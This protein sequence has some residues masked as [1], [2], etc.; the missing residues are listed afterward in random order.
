MRWGDV[1][2][3]HGVLG[4]ATGAAAA[5]FGLLPWIA[6]GMHLPL[7]NL[8]ADPSVTRSDMPIA[9]LPF[10]QY[11]VTLV[12][13][14][15]LVG[16]ATAGLLVRL[17]GRRLLPVGRWSALAG[18]LLVQLVALVQT[19]VVTEAGLHPAPSAQ[20]VADPMTNASELYLTALVAGTLGM[21]ALGAVVFSVLA[22]APS[23]VAVVALAV[24]SLA[25]GAWSNGLV[26]PISRVPDDSTATTLRLIRW[27]PAVVTGIGVAA[28]R[29]RSPARVMGAGVA[30]LVVWVGT[31]AV[32]AVAS[33][34]GSRV[35][36]A[37]PR[38]LADYA[39]AVFQAALGP[40]GHGLG[41]AAA[42]A[43]IGTTGALVVALTVRWRGRPIGSD[44]ASA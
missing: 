5:L 25:F 43:V 9:L 7:Q 2:V 18:V 44:A 41:L 14:L 42:A 29:L 3:R 10:S 33:A 15:V 37:R 38:E 19:T 26:A 34:V 32:T 36:L 28:T 11:Q 8:W 16:S 13:A 31:A 24:A 30:A 39:A 6:T 21:I 27:L 23:P 4:L 17:L 35:L 40:A 20:G 12:A 1:R 22:T